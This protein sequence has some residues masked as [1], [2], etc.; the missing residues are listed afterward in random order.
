MQVV[1]DYA[2]HPTEVKATL[3]AARDFLGGEG[4]LVVAFQPHLYSRT[5][6]LYEKFAEQLKS[7]DVIMLSDIY[8]ARETPIPGVSSQLIADCFKTKGDKDIMFIPHQDDLARAALEIL[9]PGDLFV[10]LGA[11]TIHQVGEKVLQGLKDRA[12]AAR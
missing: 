11:G 3:S 7:A 6:L 10:T 8:P 5:Q 9:Q 1:D 2:H 4:R 12:G